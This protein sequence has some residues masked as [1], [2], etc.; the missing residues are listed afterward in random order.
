MCCSLESIKFVVFRKISL[1]EI[2]SKNMLDLR[3]K[4][5]DI[6]FKFFSEVHLFDSNILMAQIEEKKIL[7]LTTKHINL[8]KNVY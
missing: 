3:Y 5:S 6:A 2:K 1:K 7:K 8:L 4:I